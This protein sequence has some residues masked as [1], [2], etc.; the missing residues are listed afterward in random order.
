MLPKYVCIFAIFLIFLYLNF[1]DYNIE[2]MTQSQVENSILPLDDLKLPNVTIPKINLLKPGETIELLDLPYCNQKFNIKYGSNTNYVLNDGKKIYQ[3]ILKPYEQQA[4]IGSE[5]QALVQI[6]W[7]KSFFTFNGKQ[8]GLELHFTHMN[9]NTG[10]KVMVIFP[11]SF[12]SKETFVEVSSNETALNNFG[13]L[14]MLLQES[15]DV[16]KL[17]KGQVNTGKLLSFNLCEPAKFILEQKK[18]F[19][20]KTPNNDVLLIS[21][22]QSFDRNLGLTILKNLQELDY[23][24]IKN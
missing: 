21:K 24:I 22:P 23:D 1:T 18:F 14:T 6:S 8:V 9:S 5:K 12:D 7:K 11:L 2:K 16:P 19:F 15:S 10:K 4:Y 13:R 3:D 20:A 17:I